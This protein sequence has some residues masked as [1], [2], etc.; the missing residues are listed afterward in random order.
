MYVLGIFKAPFMSPQGPGGK[1]MVTLDNLDHLNYLRFTFNHFGP[2]ELLPYLN[3]WIMN[4]HE[5]S[6]TDQA[7]P[8][9]ESLDRSVMGNAQLLLCFNG[10]TVYIYFGRNCDPWYINEICKVPDFAHIDRHIGEEEIFA[11]GY[12]E[13]SSYLVALYNIINNS[14]RSQR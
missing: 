1:Q 13:Q 2:E 5:A 4:I 9:L 10:M 11:P 14:L 8:A 6:L 3:P 7:P 12:Y